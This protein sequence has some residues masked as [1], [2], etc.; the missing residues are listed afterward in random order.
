LKTSSA[1]KSAPERSSFR[2]RLAAIGLSLFV[3]IAL[4]I[5]K[6]FAYYLTGSSA[7]F[8]DALESII[9]VVASAFAVV[10]IV[11]AAKPPDESHPYGHGKIEFFSAGFEGA[12]I[13]LAAVGI[14]RNAAAHILHPGPLPNLGEGLA[15][16]L[17][18]TV[19][20]LLLGILLLGTGKRT[21]SLT[22]IADGKHVLTDVYTS[23]G[24]LAGLVLVPVT[25]WY[26]LDGVIAGLVGLNILWTGIG[27]LRQAYAGLMDESDPGLL[28]EVS[29][30]LARNRNDLWIDI[31]QLRAWKAGNH[32][33]IDLHVV[34]PRDLDLNRAHLEA[35]RI[36]SIL[37]DH[38]AENASI[39]VHMDP[40][41][42]PDCPACR[43]VRCEMRMAEARESGKWDPAALTATRL[44]HVSS[45][46]TGRGDSEN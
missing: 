32:V 34:L 26:R 7:I 1:S 41:T 22:L 14:F 44:D 40:C 24:V 21:D 33:H 18:A 42:E 11:T 8:S 3:G 10:S 20:N 45:S 17:A 43:R 31:H 2:I 36:E 6:F 37:I 35:K 19:A 23:A 5:A 12:L 28:A 30:L 15:I 9:N 16:L 29:A 46:A 25:G 38:F 27:L 4:M 13:I 39:L